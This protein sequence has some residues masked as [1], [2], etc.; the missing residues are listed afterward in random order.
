MNNTNKTSFISPFPKK[1]VEFIRTINV[2]KQNISR[3]NSSDKNLTRLARDIPPVLT[4]SYMAKNKFY[5]DL[6]KRKELIKGV[7]GQNMQTEM[8]TTHS[9]KS[10]CI[11]NM[12]K[13]ANMMDNSKKKG[14]NILKL[15]NETKD[16]NSKNGVNYILRNNY[17]STESNS[18]FA[19]RTDTETFRVVPA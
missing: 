7:S 9:L 17:S 5:F 8:T 18:D 14:K 15:D 16:L 10:H 1:N 12:D 13:V 19:S 3:L 11:I 6:Q 2:V 4:K